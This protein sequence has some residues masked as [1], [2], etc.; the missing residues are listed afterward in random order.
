MVILGWL[1]YKNSITRLTSLYF[2]DQVT[3][4]SSR[5]AYPIKWLLVHVDYKLL[6]L[7]A[8]IRIHR[9]DHEFSHRSSPLGCCD[10]IS[11]V[12]TFGNQAMQLCGFLS[13]GLLYES[14]R[15]VISAGLT[16]SPWPPRT[17]GHLTN[18][19]I[20]PRIARISCCA[21]LS[22]PSSTDFPS[23]AVVG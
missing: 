10:A 6:K 22:R 21:V 4:S 18:P 12:Q 20:S 3:R 14:L 5:G 17:H 19:S 23:I 9:C 7:C 8:G 11:P 15:T 1:S 16:S 13:R 2:R